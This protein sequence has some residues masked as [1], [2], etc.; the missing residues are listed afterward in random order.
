[1]RFIAIIVS[2]TRGEVVATIASEEPFQRPFFIPE[3]EE[4]I[5][6]VHLGAIEDHDWRDLKGNEC[7]PTQ[8]IH[9]RLRASPTKPQE[10]V[11]RRAREGV[12]WIAALAG[13]REIH[14]TPTTLDAIAARLREK[15]PSAIPERVAH[16]LEFMGVLSSNEMDAAGLPRLTITRALE[17]DAIR[18]KRGV[19]SRAQ[20]FKDRVRRRRAAP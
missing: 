2:H 4:E 20:V 8:H 16:W 1:M 9:E 14:E 19:G 11:E 5:E 13:L 15:G 10:L 6:T 7:G 3:G 17:F 18:M 12:A